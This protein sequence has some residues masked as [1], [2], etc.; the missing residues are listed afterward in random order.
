VNTINRNKKLLGLT[1]DIQPNLA[2][3]VTEKALFALFQEVE[4][5]ENAIRKDP[6]QRSTELLK[7]VFDYADKQQKP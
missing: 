1:A 6:I 2:T 7:K 4:I 5:Q 3:Y